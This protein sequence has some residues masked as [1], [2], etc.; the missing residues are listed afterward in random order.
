[1]GGDIAGLQ[2]T[3]ELE[4]PIVRVFAWLAP[5]PMD[6]SRMINVVAAA[7]KQTCKT[8]EDLGVCLCIDN[9]AGSLAENPGETTSLVRLVNSDNI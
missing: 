4:A 5:L 8:A 7:L 2:K 1:M 3:G 6:K 9:H